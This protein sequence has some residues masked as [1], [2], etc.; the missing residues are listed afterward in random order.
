MPYSPYNYV[1]NN[2]MGLIDPDGRMVEDPPSGIG[3]STT[4]YTLNDDY[5]HSIN[6]H[7]ELTIKEGGVATR[8]ITDEYIEISNDGKSVS[9]SRSTVTLKADIIGETT[10][11]NPLDGDIVTTDRMGESSEV[12][13]VQEWDLSVDDLSDNGTKET[14]SVIS[15]NVEYNQRY[16]FIKEGASER[17]FVTSVVVGA[18]LVF[19]KIPKLGKFIGGGMVAAGNYY[20][21]NRDNRGRTVSTIHEIETRWE[22]I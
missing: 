22:K 9:I 5:S 4:S 19:S 20:N 3:Y 21:A 16:D 8:T 11:E 6:Y 2:P 14:V 13:S 17:A 12:S 10:I 7:K 1:L 18:G 15:Q